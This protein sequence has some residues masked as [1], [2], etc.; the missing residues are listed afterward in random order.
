MSSMPGCAG[1]MEGSP[2]TLNPENARFEVHQVIKR[3]D[4]GQ[5]EVRPRDDAVVRRPPPV[6]Q[7]RSDRVA[8][9]GLHHLDWLSVGLDDELL[10]G[11]EQAAA[12][13]SQMHARFWP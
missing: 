2:D 9:Q 7:D 3:R 11:F 10:Q 8:W 1:E 13:F 12:T 4:V 5:L 6:S